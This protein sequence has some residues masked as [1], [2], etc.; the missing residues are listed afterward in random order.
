MAWFYPS[1]KQI[2]TN[3]YMND[4]FRITAE[5]ERAH[6]KIFYN[7]LKQLAGT[8][9]HVDG[10]YPVDIYSNIGELLKAAQHNEYTEHDIIYKN[11]GDI[12]QAEGF[13]VIAASFHN[14]AEIEKTHGDRFGKYEKLLKEGLLFSSEKEETWICLNCGHIYTGLQVPSRCPVCQEGQGYFIRLFAPAAG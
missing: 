3:G 2:V 13:P 6:A 14:I 7:H 11:F 5:Q 10:S 12:A 4:L 8:T 1:C 9:I